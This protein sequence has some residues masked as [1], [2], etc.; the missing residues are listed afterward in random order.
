MSAP[1]ISAQGN[2][3]TKAV[4]TKAIVKA[5][6]DGSVPTPDPYVSN[7]HKESLCLE[8]VKDFNSNFTRLFPERS[9]LFLTTRNEFGVEKFVCT[10]VRPTQLQYREMYDVK[11][12]ATFVAHYLDYEPLESPTEPPSSLP[13]STQVLDW[14][15]GDSFDFAN[16]LCSYLLGAGYDAYVVMGYAPKDVCE[17]DQTSTACPFLVEVTEEESKSEEDAAEV[18]EG[19]DEEEAGTSY[20]A[21]RHGTIESKFL[22]SKGK[23]EV[24]DGPV[25]KPKFKSEPIK[26]DSDIED[27]NTVEQLANSDKIHG[28][29]VHA[30]VLVRGGKRDVEEM[31]F[32]E[33]TT[34]RI[35]PVSESPYLGIESVW[36]SKNYWVNMQRDEEVRAKRRAEKARVLDIKRTYAADTSVCAEP[37]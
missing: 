4:R 36:N 6:K 5:A 2:R 23:E 17:R 11:K 10:S 12:C 18:E 32:V 31:L 20:V 24:F 15:I 33:P 30:W 21:K 25:P 14:C 37:Y 1:Q 26:W 22:A 16:V 34:A 13:S 19:K 3:S 27:E 29:R 7:D 35:Y 28:K 8:F 9:P